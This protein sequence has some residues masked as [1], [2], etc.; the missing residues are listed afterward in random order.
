MT[1]TKNFIFVYAK[2]YGAW[3]FLFIA[4]NKLILLFFKISNNFI[5]TDTMR[6]L[7]FNNTGTDKMKKC[8]GTIDD[9]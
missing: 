5:L 4:G 3:I 1:S 7:S 8:T 2:I 6:W 9:T